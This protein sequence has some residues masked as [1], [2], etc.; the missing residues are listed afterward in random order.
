MRKPALAVLAI[1]ILSA[2]LSSTAVANEAFFEVT[3]T[4]LTKGIVFTPVLVAST[5]KGSPPVVSRS[6]A[7][8]YGY[9]PGIPLPMVSTATSETFFTPGTPASSE[10]EIIAETGNSVP[11]AESLDALD[12]VSTDFI[13]PGGSE[14]VIVE[15]G[16]LYTGVTV[17]AMLIPTND[18]FLALNGV[19]GP[20]GNMTHSYYIL[21]WDAGTEMN[22]ELCANL[23]GPGC[24]PDAGPASM[25]GEGYI[26]F[27]TGIHGVGDVDADLRDFGTLVAQITIT[28][29]ELD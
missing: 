23:P 18:A 22:D 2:A 25:N 21:A 8:I 19:E 14:T 4:N 12:M 6:G 5:R 3:V 10:L 1:S 24:G 13:G 16:G 27:S 29:M 9:L 11:L 17:A 26:H 20:G 28:R 7:S 15:T